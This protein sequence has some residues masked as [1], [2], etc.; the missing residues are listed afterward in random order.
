MSK[1]SDDLPEPDNPVITTSLSLGI[2]ISMFLRL[3]SR[4]PL[5]WIK[6]WGIQL[7]PHP[8]VDP[9]CNIVMAYPALPL[10]WLTCQDANRNLQDIKNSPPY[11]AI[12]CDMEQ[13]EPSQPLDSSD[14]CEDGPGWLDLIIAQDLVLSELWDNDLDGAYDKI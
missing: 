14:D 4:A 11:S 5:T 12:W 10:G 9:Y 13:N 6:S 8:I 3:C 7:H 2:V 1:A